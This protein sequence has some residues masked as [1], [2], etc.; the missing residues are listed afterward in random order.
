VHILKVDCSKNVILIR[1]S[2]LFN[3]YFEIINYLNLMCCS[4][5]VLQ[6]SPMYKNLCT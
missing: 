5:S 3:M 2:K 6:M 1:Q 4:L